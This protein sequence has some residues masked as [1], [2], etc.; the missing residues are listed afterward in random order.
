MSADA[1][2]QLA[3]LLAALTHPDTNAIREAEVA[4][5]PLLKDGRSVPALVEVL[6]SRGTQVCLSCIGAISQMRHELC[7]DQFC[8]MSCARNLCVFVPEDFWPSFLGSKPAS[9]PN[10]TA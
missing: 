1:A 10:W 5:K 3:Q 4:L 7:C 8:S 6:K 9:Y 2:A